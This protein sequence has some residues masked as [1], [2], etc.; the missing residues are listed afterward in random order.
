MR[1]VRTSMLPGMP[2]IAGIPKAEPAPMKTK[3]PPAR[4]LGAMSGSVT[5][6]RTRS[7]EAPETREASSSV[8]SIF[9]M[10]R[11]MVI[12]AKGE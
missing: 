12:K 8:G 9:S 10:A 2:T 7:G 3:R 1:V 11:E 4:I 5:S 6:H